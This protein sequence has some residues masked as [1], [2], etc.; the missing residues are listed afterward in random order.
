M[1]E[2]CRQKIKIKN[3]KKGKELKSL[4]HWMAVE[5]LHTPSGRSEAG[6]CVWEWKVRS[7]SNYFSYSTFSLL[8]SVYFLGYENKQAG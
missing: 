1:R 5:H 3:Y 8:L 4:R 7:S 6:I 2:F